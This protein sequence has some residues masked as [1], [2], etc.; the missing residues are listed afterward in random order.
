VGHDSEIP[1]SGDFVARHVGTEPVIMVRGKDGAVSVLVNRCMHRGTMVCPAERGNARTFTCA[2]HG[3]TYE[4]SGELLGVPYPGGYA[5]FDKSA[6]GLTRAPRVSSYRGFVFASQLLQTGHRYS[7][8]PASLMRRLISNIEVAAADN[9]ELVAESNFALA[10]LAIQDK[11]EMHWWV[12]RTTHRLRPVGGALKMC[13]K[14]VVL[15]NAAEP[16]P[17]L[18]FLI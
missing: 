9:G 1:R 14:T 4:I 7:Q 17:N 8:E 5:A 3:W 2:Y 16:L 18:S 6:H 12:G 15:V 10:E 11:R 13:R